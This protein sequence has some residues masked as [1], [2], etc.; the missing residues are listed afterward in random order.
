VRVLHPFPRFRPHFASDGL[1]VEKLWP[2]LVAAGG[3]HDTDPNRGGGLVCRPARSQ[4][5]GQCGQ[6]LFDGRGRSDL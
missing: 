4:R 6:G 3:G 1:Y 5:Q 2:H